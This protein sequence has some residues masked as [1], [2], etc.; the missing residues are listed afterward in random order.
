MRQ[1]ENTVHYEILGPIRVFDGH[2]ESQLNAEKIRTLL[3][4]LII[5]RDQILT[6]EQLI[7]ELWADR[8]PRRA[9]A[10]LHVYISQLRKL[11]NRTIDTA[12]GITTY[13]S[14]YAFSLGSD[15]LDLIEFKKYT[16]R[17]RRYLQIGASAD[18]DQEL[19]A[20]LQ[21]CRGPA[22]GDLRADGPIIRGFVAWAEEAELEARNLWI[23][24][25][26]SQKNYGQLISSLS[27][28]TSEYPLRESFHHQLMVALHR[29]G[30]QHDAINVY[31]RF[32]EGL[33][34]E[35]GIGPS[36]TL[37]SLYH[38]IIVGDISD[39]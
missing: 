15:S 33:S 16:D 2:T 7:A 37:R 19:T 14:G 30:R 36:A 25:Q 18:A 6:K 31:Q 26:L 8:V 23:E 28:L 39:I 17:G 20:A 11:F 1:G 10:S 9:C 24:T 35:L 3:S 29:S 5:R 12:S 22:L 34:N 38:S 4:V 32:S 21:L 13:A 27:Q